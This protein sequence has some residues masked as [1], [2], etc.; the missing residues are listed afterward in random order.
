MR[1]TFFA[2]NAQSKFAFLSAETQEGFRFTLLK[3]NAIRFALCIRGML[4]EYRDSSEGRVL[5]SCVHVVAST[6]PKI[7]AL[8]NVE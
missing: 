5:F 4:Y 6:H 2:S 3:P 8:P 1:Q 7:K